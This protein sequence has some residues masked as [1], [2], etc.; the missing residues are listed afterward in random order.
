MG[1]RGGLLM[2]PFWLP[3]TLTLSPPAGRGDEVADNASRSRGRLP[4]GLAKN[5]NAGAGTLR[6]F[7]SRQPFGA[8]AGALAVPEVRY[9]SSA[10]FRSGRRVSRFRSSPAYRLGNLRTSETEGTRAVQMPARVIQIGKFAMHPAAN[11]GEFADHHT[12]ASNSGATSSGPSASAPRN[13][14]CGR[15][16]RRASVRAVAGYAQLRST[17]PASEESDPRSRRCDG[18][19]LPQPGP[20]PLPPLRPLS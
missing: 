16:C 17:A 4:R 19:A 3:L 18:A 2:P 7:F 1:C 12:S 15:R 8:R 6:L 11:D 9:S 5:G 14:C 20:P 10:R 13:D